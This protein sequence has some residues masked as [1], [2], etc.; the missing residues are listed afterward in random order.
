MF[1]ITPPGLIACVVNTP[2]PP[3][4]FSDGRNERY[5]CVEPKESSQDKRGDM[6]LASLF[7]FMVVFW[8][9]P[10]TDTRTTITVGS[11]RPMSLNKKRR[12]RR[13]VFRIY[14]KCS[15]VPGLIRSV[16]DALP[17]PLVCTPVPY[18]PHLFQ[19]VWKTRETLDCPLQ[20]TPIYSCLII[21]FKPIQESIPLQTET[22]SSSF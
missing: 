7:L 8:W 5:G 1:A 10:G 6:E 3:P 13:T 14:C 16:H 11:A 19:G 15:F 18:L 22:T 17:V 9:R 20:S 21:T 2:I 12:R 4:T